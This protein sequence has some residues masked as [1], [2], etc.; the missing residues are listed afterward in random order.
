MSGPKEMDLR[1]D[2]EVPL[3]PI[4]DDEHLRHAHWELDYDGAYIL[5]QRAHGHK[6]WFE[7]KPLALDRG[8]DDALL[9]RE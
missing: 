5:V 3:L 7:V 1:Y 6:G 9:S 2:E 8:D 4:D